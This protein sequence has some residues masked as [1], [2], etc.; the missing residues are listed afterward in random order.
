MK[1]LRWSSPLLVAGLALALFLPSLEFHPSLVDRGWNPH[2]VGMSVPFER[3]EPSLVRLVAGLL[4]EGSPRERSPARCVDV[5]IHAAGAATLT[6]V[7]LMAGATTAPAVIAGALF[8]V[9]PATIDAVVRGGR[10]GERL[11]V[12]LFLVALAFY[13][14]YARKALAGGSYLA[15]LLFYV[16]ATTTHPVTATG[17]VVF[18]LFDVWPLRR[19]GG[20]EAP[21]GD[22][23]AARL[24]AE[25]VPFIVVA[26]LGWAFNLVMGDPRALGL[27]TSRPPLDAAFVFLSSFGSALTA[28]LAALPA[29]VLLAPPAVS[30]ACLALVLVVFVTRWAMAHL[31]DAPWMAVGWLWGLALLLPEVVRVAGDAG[32]ITAPSAYPALPGLA[33]AFA[34]ALER[35]AGRILPALSSAIVAT[36]FAVSLVAL[37]SW[38]DDTAIAEKASRGRAAVEGLLLAAAASVDPSLRVPILEDAAEKAPG[39]ADVQAALATAFCD[40]GDEA[41]AAGHARRAARNKPS[42]LAARRALAC[43]LALLG[44]EGEAATIWEELIETARDAESMRR[45]GSLRLAGGDARAAAEHFRNA[46]LYRPDDAAAAEGLARALAVINRDA[47][48]P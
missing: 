35:R 28:A 7:L 32:A 20:N 12:A 11:A 8:A 13:V 30:R 33:I 1:A 39:R 40:L 24:A 23:S 4:H 37:P 45:L 41:A 2:P 47:G 38:R 6:G 22:G 36:L 17:F 31:A 15:A 46:L 27:A 34:W 14:R 19:L 29:D 44:R 16:A 21:G 3:R 48:A 18:A 25:K 9:H 26:G 43:S 10:R 42:S 5:G